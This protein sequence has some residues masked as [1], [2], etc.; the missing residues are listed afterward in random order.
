MSACRPAMRTQDGVRESASGVSNGWCVCVHAGGEH[1]LGIYK[2]Y[3]W[4]TVA[5]LVLMFVMAAW[6]VC[7]VAVNT[8]GARHPSACNSSWKCT[9]HTAS[10][11]M[12]ACSEPGDGHSA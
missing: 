1:S 3:Y 6:F 7:L 4:C 9:T 8:T 5:L 11:D 2:A 12:P 10:M